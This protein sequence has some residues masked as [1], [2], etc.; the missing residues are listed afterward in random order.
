MDIKSTSLMQKLINLTTSNNLDRT[1]G[2]LANYFLL[3]YDELEH[4]PLNQV[5]SD[6]F[7]SIS[8]VRR[9]C[10]KIG[11][12]NYTDLI[13]SKLRNPEKQK[14]IAVLNLHSGRYNP[15][16]LRNEINENLYICYRSIAPAQIQ[17]LVQWIMRSSVLILI[18]TR[19]YSLWIR[20]FFNQLVA[21]GKL[22]Y[23]VED[24]TVCKSVYEKFGETSC[25]IVVSPMGVLPDSYAPEIQNL[26]GKK[27]LI[28]GK[29]I[30]HLP[31]FP[32]FSK[33]YDDLILLPF[34]DKSYEYMEILGK[35]TIGFLFD[36]ILGEIINY[37]TQHPQ[38]PNL[39]C[40]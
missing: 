11:Y 22:T 9:F 6:C 28:A 16:M 34:K 15:A 1:C 40:Y 2:I 27:I 5:V 8:S 32:L 37:L 35:Y 23:T 24:P 18:S 19:P 12:E 10:Q 13:H 3:H 17:M 29:F 30:T 26:P 20:E 31:S 36:I 21:W 25:S 4:I 14:E 38:N 7:L 33:Q 39:D